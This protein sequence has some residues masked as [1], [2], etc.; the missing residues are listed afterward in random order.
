V[1]IGFI[2]IDIKTLRNLSA[3]GKADNLIMLTVLVLTV[4]WNLVFAVL[5]GLVMASFHFMKRMSDVVEQDTQRTRVDELVS[6]TIE[7][8]NDKII[9]S[10]IQLFAILADM[11]ATN[12]KGRIVVERFLRSRVAAERIKG[13]L[14]SY[15]SLLDDRLKVTDKNGSQRKKTSMN[16]V[17]VLKICT[18]INNDLEREEKF[19]LLIRLAEFV[20]ADQDASEQEWDFVHVVA[21]VFGLS[22]EELI[23]AKYLASS[24][25]RVD[26]HEDAA[27]RDAQSFESSVLIKNIKG[28]VFFGFSHRFLVS[29]RNIA[30][31]IKVVV[32]NMAFVPFMDHS[33]VRT[34]MEVAT[35]L[36]NKGVQVCFSGLSE[37]NLA[38]LKGAGVIPQL[39]KND[40][41]FD[42]IQNCIIWLNQPGAA[43]LNIRD[44]DALYPSPIFQI[45]DAGLQYW[46]ISKID[47]LPYAIVSIYDMQDIEVY[48]SKGYNPPWK[49]MYQEHPL[50]EGRYKYEIRSSE[51]DVMIKEGYV[52]LL[53]KSQ[54]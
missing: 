39:V 2:L 17:K 9:R 12:E 36:S 50:P 8:F 22:N 19:Y 53:R 31:E 30:P 45:D 10:L 48:S 13:Y 5:I 40:H 7:R 54:S 3:I 47:Q 32:L 18:L 1:H 16:S 25:L 23:L 20:N 27:L 44:E 6:E 42:T 41:V 21:E 33:G 43:R 4:T 49:G 24:D 28:P 51:K 15:D 34:F 14:D 26:K 37:R 38:L 29:M 52:I 35:F 11:K 46:N